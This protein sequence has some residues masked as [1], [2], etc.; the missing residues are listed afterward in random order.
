MLADVIREKE[1]E[2]QRLYQAE[3]DKYNKPYKRDTIIYFNTIH[4]IGGI[5]TWI[6]TLGKKYEFSVVYDNADETQLERLHSVGIE[7]IKNVGQPIEC[8]TLLFMLWDNNANITAKK[9]Y[10]F[11]HGIYEN[12]KEVGDIPEYDEIYAVSKTASDSF[13]KT[14]GIKPKV[15]YNPIDI[16]TQLEPLIIGVF[17]R[18]SKEKGKDRI[19]Y[20]LDKLNE[21]N[22]PYLMLIFTDLPFD[23]PD[24]RVVFMK[25]TLNNIGWMKKCD[26]I[27]NPSDKE[28]GSYTLQEAL[29]ISKPLIVTKLGILEEFGI[30]ESNSKILEMDMRNLDVEDLWNIPKFKWKEPISK[31]WEDIMKKKV[32]REKNMEIQI[33]VDSVEIPE[34]IKET[35]E[36]KKDK[37]KTEKKKVKK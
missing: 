32:F 36:Q 17:S 20:L 22:K 7:T 1:R 35:I 13:Y 11:I 33:V 26:Y 25:P 12:I 28:A 31:E 8:N 23:Y 9:R 15:I 21:Q 2:R 5:E 24:S 4:V 34:A 27:L 14:T 37:P 16:E 29:K 3:I 10:L 30:N 19:I 18:L 6:Y